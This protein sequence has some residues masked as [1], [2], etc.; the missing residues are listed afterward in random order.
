MAGS[1][2]KKEVHRLSTRT[3]LPRF[4]PG[5]SLVCAVELLGKH[6]IPCALI[7]GVAIWAY[8]PAS[9]QRLTK[10]VDLA[11]PGT[12]SAQVEAALTNAGHRPIPL[13][14]G[15][16][17]VREDTLRADFIDRRVDF[18]TLYQDAVEEAG[19]AQ[20]W[21]EIDGAQVLLV[22]PEYLVAMKLAT[23]ERDD[24]HDVERLLRSSAPP[25]DLSTARE[26]CAQRLGPAVA[27]RLDA[28]ARGVGHPD[29][30]SRYRS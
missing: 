7:G 8:V 26:L 19:Q 18:A 11:V 15:G 30:R 27:N 28:L 16:W 13:E 14:I 1:G 4:D 21:A 24:E 10:D 23:G 25:V 29:A 20:R 9:E 22:S 3:Q 5:P 17:G 12:W 6:Q 2:S